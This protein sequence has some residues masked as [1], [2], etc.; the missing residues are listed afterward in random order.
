MTTSEPGEDVT[1]PA[2]G[3]EEAEISEFVTPTG[4]SALGEVEEQEMP[5]EE[6]VQTIPLETEERTPVTEE[7]EERPAPGEEAVQETAMEGEKTPLAEEARQETTMVGEKTPPREEEQPDM[8]EQEVTPQMKEEQGQGSSFE[9]ASPE[10][11]APKKR[12]RKK[13]VK[14][15]TKPAAQIVPQVQKEPIKRPKRE[16]AKKQKAAPVE[17][18]PPPNQARRHLNF[19]AADSMVLDMEQLKNRISLQIDQVSF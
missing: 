19:S 7:E 1:K 3:V 4:K 17:P 11:Q 18:T 13:K 5:T 15:E 8:M 2:E 16:S 12:G 10:V 9:T 14:E 6:K